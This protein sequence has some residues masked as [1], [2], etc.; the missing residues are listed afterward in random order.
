MTTEKIKIDTVFD[1]ESLHV[2]QVYA[3]ALLA[4]AGTDSSIDQ[5]VEELKAVVTDVLNKQ[6]ALEAIFANPR[7]D[8]ASKVTMLDR[9]FASRISA[10]LLNFLKVVARRRRLGMLRSIEKSVG[11]MRDAATGRLQVLLTT[12]EPLDETAMENIRTALSLKF[13]AEVSVSNKV[14]PSILAGLVIRVGDVV[15]DGSVDGQLKNLRNA[16]VAKAEQAIRD[17]LGSLAS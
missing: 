14:D 17:R 9:M 8:V 3:K 15:Y 16:T 1:D 10:T 5:V 7:I 13:K 12:A 2:G 11:I 4:A 6:P